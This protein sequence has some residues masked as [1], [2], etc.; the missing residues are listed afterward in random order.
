[1]GLSARMRFS[2][3][4][5][6]RQL[7]R[8]AESPLRPL[9]KVVGIFRTGTNLARDLLEEHYRVKVCYSKWG[10]K[11]GLPPSL[12]LGGRQ[13]TYP[14]PTLVMSRDPVD[15]NLS[16]YKFWQKTRPELDTGGS[17]SAFIR[18]EFIVYDNSTAGMPHYLYQT[19]TEYWNQFYYAYLSWSAARSCLH[20]L[21]YERLVADPEAEIAA[22][23]AAASLS[24]RST[25]PVRLPQAEV[26]PSADGQ[27]SSAGGTAFIAKTSQIAPEDRAFIWAQTRDSIAAQ[28][29]YF[30]EAERAEAH[31]K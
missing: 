14:V 13:L 18:Q 2:V 17:L 30:P 20:F 6:L 24:R 23:A 15:A 27:A 9:V 21:A 5:R 3:A 22:F 26:L 12:P 8:L 28:L 11:H 19:P 29:G 10:W 25:G 7:D 16:L 31:G 1:M 4:R